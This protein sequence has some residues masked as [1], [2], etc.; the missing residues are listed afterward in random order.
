M[1]EYRNRTALVTGA[2][3]GLG[4]ALARD[5]ASRG[6][7]LVLVA[8]SA[9]RLEHLADELRAQ[10]GVQVNAISADLGSDEGVQTVLAATAALP[11]IDLLVNN[12]G[13]GGVGSFVDRPLDEAIAP[14][15][16]NVIGLVRLTHAVAGRMA[17]DGRGGI[18]NIGSTGA[19]QPMPFQ[20]VYSST[21]AFVLMF[22]EALAEELRARGVRVMIASPGPTATEFFADSEV[23]PA[24]RSLDSADT[25]AR[26]I[27]DDFAAGRTASYP[28]RRS[29]RPQT[30]AARILP[31][32]AV[33]RITGD[34]ARKNGF[35]V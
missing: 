32:T 25:V 30:W 15:A 34:L 21:K 11:A 12:A 14:I 23:D 17:N 2:S 5:L 4:T 1:N 16:V 9:S 29:N 20:N 19:F 10:Y 13:L 31:R 18:I 3:K 22:T 27:L 8:R 7:H 6:S 26:D 24:V 28:G 33:T 35:D